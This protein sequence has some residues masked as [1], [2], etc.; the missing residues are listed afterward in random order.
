MALTVGI[1]IYAYSCIYYSL[2]SIFIYNINYNSESMPSDLDI[3]P[4]KIPKEIEKL[5][6]EMNILSNEL[7]F[8]EAGV[9]RDK[10]KILKKLEL[11]YIEEIA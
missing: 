3:P 9:L 6:K 8:E 5:R 10:I 1:I 7:K 11:A 4:H 2:Y